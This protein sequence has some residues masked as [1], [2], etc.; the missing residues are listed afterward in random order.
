MKR[1][2]EINEIVIT[3]KEEIVQVA[4]AL[5]N[6]SAMVLEPQEKKEILEKNPI[7]GINECFKFIF[8]KNEISGYFYSYSADPK[9][10]WEDS[11]SKPTYENKEMDPM[12]PV[13][14]TSN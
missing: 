2:Q 12:D 8:S 6:H 14:T 5:K 4:N 9:R 3:K 10:R 1:H 7:S 13:S 11:N